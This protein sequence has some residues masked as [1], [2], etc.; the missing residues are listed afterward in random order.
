MNKPWRSVQWG[1]LWMRQLPSREVDAAPVHNE[2]SGEEH[3]LQLPP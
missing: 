3:R 2:G 1:A